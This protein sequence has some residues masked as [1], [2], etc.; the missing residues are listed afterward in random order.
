MKRKKRKK[1]CLSLL[2]ILSAA[3]SLALCQSSLYSLSSLYSVRFAMCPLRY[4]SASLCVR[5]TMCP[6][7]LRLRYVS[8]LCILCL[9]SAAASLA[10]CQCYLNVG[11]LHPIRL[12]TFLYLDYFVTIYGHIFSRRVWSRG[13]ADRRH[14]KRRQKCDKT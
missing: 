8:V 2:C 3:A 12:A 14:P 6:L 5:F 11:T 10:L 13:C 4:V 1:R 7:L 9:L